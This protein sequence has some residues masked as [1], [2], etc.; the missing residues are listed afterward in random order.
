MGVDFNGA[1]MEGGIDKQ[2]KIAW[3]TA[4]FGLLGAHT[5]LNYGPYMRTYHHGTQRIDQIYVSDLLL[6]ENLVLQTT[7]G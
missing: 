2:G 5:E 1:P 6:I 4:E 3:L 7:I